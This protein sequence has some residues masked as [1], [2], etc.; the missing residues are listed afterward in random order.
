MNVEDGRVVADTILYNGRINT[1]DAADSIAE[2]VAISGDRILA[3][4][5]DADIRRLAGRSTREVDLRGRSVIPGLIDNHTHQL[6]AGLDTAE[7]GAKVN[8][9]LC[10]TIDEIKSR[11]AEAARRLQPGE[12]ITTS[13]LF[14]GALEDGRFPNRHDL[15]QVA[16]DNPVYIADGGRNIIVNTRAL[17]LA[18]IDAGTPDPGSD[19]EVA[20]GHIVR[21]EAGVPTGH[22]I[23]GAG[24]LARRAWWK[25]LGQPIKMW[26]FLDFDHETTL[27]ALR[28]QMGVLNAAGI[29]GTRD[30]GVAPREIDVYQDLVARG[31]ATVRTDLI[32]GLPVQYLNT[33]QILE[34]LHSYMG[35]K[36]GFGDEWLRIGGL[37]IVAQNYGYWSMQPNKIR[38]LV[39]EGNRLGW[40]FAIHGTPGDLGDDIEVILDALEEADREIP[41]SGRRWSYEHA[42]GLIQPEYQERL[43]RM[44]V[45]IAANPHLSYVGA[46]RS[47]AMQSA[48]QSIRMGEPD[49]PSRALD[50]TIRKWGQP[51]RSWLAAGLLVTGG[52]DSPAVAYDREQPFLGLWATFSQETLA[53][54]LMPEETVDRQTALRIWTINNAIAT[55]EEH[56]KGSIEAGKLADLAVLTGD[57][58]TTPDEDFLSLRVEETIVGGRTVYER[59]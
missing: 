18:G 9:Q 32:L 40:S 1:I 56:L 12:W 21:D 36:Q 54:V 16:P 19:P 59:E 31:E 52:S 38:V 10:T 22:L 27:R 25:R 57:P 34:S 39:A 7:A 20:Q 48:L 8:V 49:D 5:G 24:D 45:T 2:A 55:G 29:T 26:D 46:G 14:R 51:I 17:E 44:G 13:C 47:V 42:F 11:I 6:M 53:G 50:V 4:G 28:A 43:R 3:V 41:L 58:L 15:D 37:K 33:E 35:P 30:M 23:V